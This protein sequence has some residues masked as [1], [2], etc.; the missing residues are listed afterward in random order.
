M[1]FRCEALGL[2]VIQG[3]T[4]GALDLKLD[5]AAGGKLSTALTATDVVLLQHLQTLFV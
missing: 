5:V 2:Q 1:A 3:A 4:A